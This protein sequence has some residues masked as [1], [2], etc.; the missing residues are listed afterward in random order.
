[1]SNVGKSIFVFG[2]YLV[3]LGLTLLVTPNIPLTLFGLAATS[4]VWI[5]VIGMLGLFLAFYYIQAARQGLTDFFRWTVYV[6]PLVI[7]FFA[8]FVVLG[9]AQPGLIL[10]GVPDLLGAIWTGVSLRSSKAELP[11]KAESLK[12]A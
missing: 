5:R 6:R 2:I 8:A 12:A 9:F 1:M 11:A 7:V 3:F 10:F 4:E